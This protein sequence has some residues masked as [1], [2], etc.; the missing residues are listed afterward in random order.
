MRIAHFGTF[1][2]ENYGDL[3]FPLVARHRLEAVGAEFVHVSPVGG[4]PVWEGCV[5]SVPA[6]ALDGEALDGLLLGGGNIVHAGPA[7]VDD[8]RQDGLTWLLAY[9]RLWLEPARLATV[10]GLPFCWNAPGVPSRF[11]GRV[12]EAV[13][14]ATSAAG[15]ITVRDRRSL[16][17]LR[18]AG[19]DARI[20]VVPDPAFDIVELFDDAAL[21]EAFVRIFSRRERPV[22]E[23]AL[24]VHLNDRYLDEPIEV[25][26]AR[27]DRIA[28][29]MDATVL[30]LALG[31][32]HGDHATA[33]AVSSRLSVEHVLIDRPAS[34][35]EFV[36]GLSRA[37]AYVGSSLHGLVTA[38]AFGR[39]GLVVAR[40]EEGGKFSGQLRQFR[41]EDRLIPSWAEAERRVDVLND[42]TGIARVASVAHERL[43]VH[44]ARITETLASKPLL[45]DHAVDAESTDAVLWLSSTA[46]AAAAARNSARS[47]KARR[48]VED[49]ATQLAEVH[50]TSDRNRRLAEDA[51]SRAK[52]ME[53]E[54]D[55]AKRVIAE[56]REETL[57]RAEEELRALEERY[58]R[59]GADSERERGEYEQ[60][61]RG[62]VDERDR[63]AGELERET[64]ALRVARQELDR[65]AGE[66]SQRD[67]QLD[68]ARRAT[69][70]AEQAGAAVRQELETVGGLASERAS[71]IDRL[72]RD[73]TV[74][75]TEVE[76]LRAER[77]EIRVDSAAHATLS[78]ERKATIKRL[79]VDLTAAREEL[80]DRVLRLERAKGELVGFEESAQRLADSHAWRLGHWLMRMG[81]W[82]TFRRPKG[83]GAMPLLTRRAARAQE[84]LTLSP[85]LPKR[86]LPQDV[87][88]PQSDANLDP[89]VGVDDAPSR[90][91]VSGATASPNGSAGAFPRGDVP[92]PISSMAIASLVRERSS[93]DGWSPSVDVSGILRGEPATEEGSVDVVVCVH[94]ALDDVHRCLSSVL[95][96]STLPLRLIIVDDGSGEETARYLDAFVARNP[97]VALQRNV[98]PPHGYTVA[99]NIGLRAST[100]DYVILLNSDTVVTR[101]WLEHLVASGRADDRVGIIGPLSNAASHQSVP[102]SRDGQD[103]AINELPQWLTEDGL[104]LLVANLPGEETVSV[105]FLNGFCY[106]VRRRTINAIG[107][108]DEE[109]FA[110]GYSEE[111]DYSR[112]AAEAGFDLRVA[113]RAYVFH[114]K[115]RSYGHEE[116]RELAKRHYRIFLERHGEREVRQLVDS[117]HQN[118]SLAALRARVGEAITDPQQ[119]V[120][121]LPRLRVTF[122]LPGMAKGGSGGS[123]SIYQEVSAMRSVGIQARV[124]L[125][126][127][128]QDNAAASYPEA[129]DLFVPYESDGHLAELTLGDDVIVATHYTSVSAVASLVRE[130]PACLGAYYVQDYE[131]LFSSADSAG[132]AEAERSYT[133]IPN[134]LL[135]AKTEWL[136]RT[137]AERTGAAVAKV[138]PSID[139]HVFH[140]RGR[141][142]GDG[143]VRVVAMLRPRTPRRAPVET[144]AVL[145]RIADRYGDNVRVTTFGCDDA[146]FE[147]LNAHASIMHHG[148]LTR[149]EVADVLREADAFLDCSWYQAFGRT[150][151]EA[152]A[153]GATAVLPRSGGITEFARDGVNCL[154]TDTLDIEA[155]TAAV[156]CLVE[157]RP[158][159]DRLQAAGAETG[160]HYSAVRAAVSEY[161]LFCHAY[162]QRST[163][164]DSVVPDR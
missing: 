23:H 92:A 158:L 116:R 19:V 2:V 111:N 39:P 123:H 68:R 1:D 11:S 63:L 26:A 106:C 157:D 120:A 126:A 12:A 32:C 118:S 105:P 138:E 114:S 112:R 94:D 124:A 33:R 115:S 54:L 149:H 14:R 25:I 139:H 146:A 84:A 164:P 56:Q 127:R 38:L 50:S 55:D 65:L 67:D 156:A 86:L 45:R 147:R 119:T 78:A 75:L 46:A 134:G 145:G 130:R 74:A 117:L 62:S 64:E 137:V 72:S 37:D 121:R 161:V 40:E 101:G 131:P 61:L 154:L 141:K 90:P 160:T 159:L 28:T 163:S 7:G 133:Q 87:A 53:D 42:T 51:D 155:M 122:V 6:N 91:N 49:L 93:L 95:E 104:A 135:F 41:L 97:A 102:Q 152:M 144:L 17:N 47:A 57:A 128:S 22:P 79:E 83:A 4:P 48:Q 24:A 9:A 27:L 162:A 59:L 108:F 70:D 99:A 143:P 60:R 71:D 89:G 80:A 29:S 113:A 13:Q 98:D 77:R 5:P 16:A 107:L 153:C 15:Y 18:D 31:R 136:Q 52:R 96:R 66:L 109:H 85:V 100:A 129:A 73:L 10:H 36:A 35:L 151:L 148:I 103:W 142:V 20:D 58:E 76:A 8:Y 110:A 34:L 43:D 44:W 140:P 82:L 21:D 3:L 81:R 150:G 30:L 125:A 88:T 132:A 69:A